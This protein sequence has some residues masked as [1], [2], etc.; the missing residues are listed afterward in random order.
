MKD[1]IGFKSLLNELRLPHVFRAASQKHAYQSLELYCCT[2]VEQLLKPEQ[3]AVVAPEEKHPAGGAEDCLELDGDAET[4]TPVLDFELV[5]EAPGGSL[6][7]EAV[8]VLVFDVPLV[9]RQLEK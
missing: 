2:Q 4:A 8:R 1:A 7:L 3:D 6:E 5:A 9:D